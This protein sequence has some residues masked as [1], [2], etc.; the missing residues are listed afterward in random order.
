MV[1]INHS[2]TLNV[3]KLSMAY[4][5]CSVAQPTFAQD[6]FYIEHKPTGY[7][8]STCETGDGSA[9]VADAS[10]DESSCSQ[11]W[12]SPIGEYFYLRHAL[13]D[14]HIRPDDNTN[15]AP[16]VLRPN[17]WTG[18]WTQWFTQDTNDGYLRLINRETAKF[19]Y[20]EQANGN[21]QLRPNTWTGD[22]TRW[23]FV[24]VDGG[25]SPPTDE[26]TPI[27]T[28]VPTGVPTDVPTPTPTDPPNSSTSVE[29]ESG[30]I[31]GTASVYNDGAASGGQGV[32]FISTEG[33]G[34]RVTAP[35]GASSLSVTYASELSGAISLRV[36]GVD[37]GNISFTSTGNWVGSYNTVDVAVSI[38]GGDAVDIF[39]S[40]GD[41]AMNVDYLTFVSGNGGGN[42]P[43]PVVTN[44]PD[45]VVTNTPDPVVTNTP[46]PVVT[47][48]PG[49]G[50]EDF[51]YESNG[52]IWFK[53]QPNW[54]TSGT[55]YSCR[56]LEQDCYPAELNNGRWERVHGN[57]TQGSTY[58]AQL[59]VPGFGADQFPQY[60]YT[61]D[62][63]TIGDGN[64]GG[65]NPGGG[66]NPPPTGCTGLGCLDW[67]SNSLLSGK[68][69]GPGPRANAPDAL[70]TPTNGAS[71][72]SHGFAFDLNG[73][74]FSWRW[75][76]LIIKGAGDSGLQVWCSTDGGLTYDSANFSGGTA[77]APCSGNFDYFFRYLHPTHSLNNNPAHQWIYT[78]P[79]TTAGSRVNPNGYASFT[80]GSSNW[81][82]FRHPISQDGTTAA[83]LDAQ[84]NNDLL[85]NLDRYNIWVNDSPGNV[86]FNLEVAGSVLRNEALRNT[87]G[88]PNGQQFFAVNQN[89]GFG[90]TFSY[91]QVI[92]F[93]VTAIAGA[94][95]A[96]TYN[97]F[98]YYTVGLGWGNYGDLRLQSAGKAGTTMIL[99][100]GGA[101]SD[102]E[103][104][105]TFTQPLVTLHSEVDMDDFILGHH[106]FHGIDPN[107]QGSTAFDVVKMGDRTCGDCHFRD[108]RGDEVIQTPRGPRLPPATYGTGL[109][110]AIQGREVGL[111]WDGRDNTMEERV[112]NAL[113]EDHGIDVSDL[114]D[115]RIF[116]L[117]VHY[118]E[119][120]TVPD[121]NP[122][123]TDDPQINAGHDAFM[124]AGCGDCHTPVQTTSSSN[125]AYDGLTIRPYTD[126]KLWNL[127]EGNFRTAP[128]WGLG[129]NINLLQRN[130]RQVLF[131]HDG[132]S[133]SINGAVQRHNG[134]AA[135][136]KAAYNSGNSSAIDAY[137]RSL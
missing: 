93:E 15:G 89:P 47:P 20:A 18:N 69:F 72:T 127:G 71:P 16:I 37:V 44:T 8:F 113:I 82:R 85:R 19:V 136:S 50:N 56:D 29:A 68:G 70:S 67:T 124:A 57:L 55:F 116:D 79:F 123:A 95:G 105:A 24:P 83:V 43:D 22:Y 25:G 129:H 1:K 58:T 40:G 48:D 115:E 99:S 27:P 96:Q 14:K 118:T 35:T 23:R 88:G 7:R 46:D 91:G 30:Q 60:Q 33:A 63:P 66:G 26:P 87:A 13:S 28:D 32:A 122:A 81:M 128:L 78:G 5:V 59:K 53:A 90:N 98:S 61:W 130:G 9:I 84:H 120:L 121:R 52:L 131:M 137:V 6:L 117:L 102:L 110:L 135:A 108:G 41:T 109:L 125:D 76:D 42:T 51:G 111:T 75:G 114:P 2:K 94:S 54:P 39:Y 74:T 34:F 119:V 126:M 17:T 100:D 45:P 65:G 134:S 3:V 103:Y 107:A 132:A 62:Y 104:N 12:Q 133:T 38:S 10:G 86:Q 36:D 101:Y 112:R 64:T 11:W 106:L 97:D 77:T 73:S 31:L 4:A 92:Q 21:L 80:D 49:N